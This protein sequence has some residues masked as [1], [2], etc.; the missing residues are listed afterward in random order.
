MYHDDLLSIREIVVKEMGVE[1]GIGTGVV[2]VRTGAI[3]RYEP[4]DSVDTTGSL[5]S[6]D[7]DVPCVKVGGNRT[8]GILAEFLPDTTLP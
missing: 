2:I 3:E 6:A 5:V 4:G 8:T 7:W 1:I